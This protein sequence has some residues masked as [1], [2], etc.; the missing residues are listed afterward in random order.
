[1]YIVSKSLQ[2]FTIFSDRALTE[3]WGLVVVLFGSVSYVP[4]KLNLFSGTRFVKVKRSSFYKLFIII[5]T[6]TR[7]KKQR[8]V[9]CCPNSPATAVVKKIGF[10]TFKRRIDNLF[11]RLD[12]VEGEVVKVVKNT[13]WLV[14][15]ERRFSVRNFCHVICGDRKRQNKVI[16]SCRS[17]F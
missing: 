11:F 8:N 1:M 13:K 2:P 3:F 15:Q 6:K 10:K 7:K 12:I 16:L 14:E 5:K 17:I 9:L 4:A